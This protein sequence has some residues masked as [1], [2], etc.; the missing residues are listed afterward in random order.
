MTISFKQIP[1]RLRVPGAFIEQTSKVNASGA[2]L[3]TVLHLG[4]ASGGSAEE[5]TIYKIGDEDEAA[6]LFGTDSIL[7]A[8]AERHF[9]LNTGLMLYAGAAKPAQANTAA[10]ATIVINEPADKDSLLSV[11]LN[12][13]LISI[14]VT[15]AQTP[16]VIATALAAAINASKAD[17][18]T[19]ANATATDDTVELV[20]TIPGMLGNSIPLMVGYNPE[21]I[22][23]VDLTVTAFNGGAGEPDLAPLL[24]DM[25]EDYYDYIVTPFAGNAAL[26]ALDT[27]IE[28]R[29]HAMAGLSVQSLGIWAFAG[30]HAAAVAKGK[31]QNSE[32]L[33]PIAT[34]DAPQAPWIWA[35]SLAAVASDPLTNDPAAPLTGLEIGGLKAPKTCWNWKKRNELLYSGMSTVTTDRA[36]NVYIEKLI[37]S[38]Q[39]DEKGIP[40]ESYLSIHVPELMRNIRR[41]QCAHLASV[42]QGYKLTDFTEQHAAN[43]KIASTESVEATLIGFYQGSLM[44]ERAW[45]TDFD[46]YKDT[47]HV[48]RDPDN[49]QRLNYQDFP[50]MIGQLEIIAGQ[51]TLAHG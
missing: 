26:R 29:W 12:D 30:D 22:P 41:V 9:T 34:S 21:E 38:Y 46:Q 32:F 17:N 31:T 25:A 43:V 10:K 20:A 13:V 47:I 44:D 45:C 2:R 14:A 37:T 36:G 23:K 4:L 42:Y 28:E 16:T 50:V 51:S 6:E 48:E 15:D 40:D 11:R 35:A 18:G 5:N 49:R 39:T 33:V 24:E 3:N 8:M 27:A 7:M 1:A 19:P